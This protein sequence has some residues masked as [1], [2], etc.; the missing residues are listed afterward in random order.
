MNCQECQDVL[1]NLL[2]AEPSAAEHAALGEHVGV[3]PGC[4]R[5]YAQAQ[6]ALADVT[7][8]CQIPV[9]PN[10]KQRIMA[11]LAAHTTC[12]VISTPVRP[13][14][15]KG[16]RIIVKSL[17]ATAA[18]VAA[19]VALWLAF[20]GNH[21]SLYAQVIDAVHNA[22]TLQMIQFAIP[23]AEGKPLKVTESWFERGVGFRTEGPGYIRLGN[24]K[25]TWSFST[26]RK[27]AVRSQSN[28]IARATAPVFAKIE[29]FAQQL[30]NE[31]ERCPASDQTIDGQPCKAY[32]L[33][34]LDRV[35]GTRELTSGQMRLM[36]FIDP[37]AKLV[38][39]EYQ[40]REDGRYI[41]K[42]FASVKYDEPMDPSLFQ[43]DFGKNVKIV[44]ADD[45]FSEFVSLKSAVHVEERSGLI[46]A[47]HRVERFDNGG[48]LVVSSVRGTEETLKKYPLTQREV[49]PGEFLIDGPATLPMSDGSDLLHLASAQHQGIDVCWWAAVPGTME[50]PT[51]FE[52]KPGTVKLRAIVRPE[53]EFATLFR[54]KNG[55]GHSLYWDVEVKVPRPDRVH[56]VE[57]IA[58]Q[59]YADQVA[60]EAIPFKWLDIGRWGA[61]TAV[62]SEIGKT[63]A[64]EY[65]K[66]I[67]EKVRSRLESDIDGQ[68][69]RQFEPKRQKEIR[70][71]MGDRV[72][73]ALS[74]SPLVDDATLQRVAGRPSV[75]EL[76]LRGTRI[77]DEGL[78]NLSGLTKL[79][80]L[81]LAETRITDEGLRYLTRL[82]SLK[83][84]DLTDTKVTADGID[85]LK[86]A[87]AGVEI[88]WKAKE[89]Q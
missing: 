54:D 58:S 75:T 56:T 29:Q 35:A 65:A 4:A 31:F 20:D 16:R 18:S 42:G 2:V 89:R 66:A 30:R 45:A 77:T 81:D 87:I 36:V 86:Q 12:E 14:V 38:R 7:P 41:T 80:K 11:A 69:D 8:D 43:P 70:K 6:Q 49:R 44:N 72:A 85:I 23:K 32:L 27:V 25:Y 26:D 40:W 22:R 17:L 24:D 39:A 68:I 37:Q 64:V 21:N 67:I 33:T 78:N 61:G 19:C 5:Q 47:I 73:I 59:V 63:S 79:D 48:V 88:K 34:K 52:V 55:V 3:C 82:S 74:F 62:F 50:P 60:L 51:Y 10:L 28:G 9:S 83:R 46:Y 53:G 15:S 13:A 84:L 71:S 76:Y 1:D 57:E